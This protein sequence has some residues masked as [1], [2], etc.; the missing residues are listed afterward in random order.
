MMDVLIPS[1]YF[2]IP[3]L[4]NREKKFDPEKAMH[5]MNKHNVKNAFMPPTALK[6]IKSSNTKLKANLRSIGSG[7]ESLGENLLSWGR[8]TFG[9]TIHE[10]YGQTEANLL[11][12]NCSDVTPVKVGSMGKAIPGRKIEIINE[13]GEILPNGQ[14]GVIGSIATDPVT[15]KCYWNKP[16]QTTEKFSQDGKWL[17]TGDLGKKDNDGYFTFI[18]RD[19]DIIK[20]AGYRVGPC[21]IED[22]ISK[23]HSV[24][25]VAVVGSPDE[26]RNEVVKAF[27]VLK[28]EYQNDISN[29]ETLKS[30]IQNFVKTKLAAYEYPR[31]IEFIKELPMTTTGK[32]IRKELREREFK[33]K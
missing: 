24:K 4:A 7:G 21:E 12:G 8:E 22:C 28:D 25:V 2:G 20:T 16:K 11:I 13:K 31:K 5:L 10:F 29:H 1:A 14:I 17:L 30:E 3:V 26:L 33:K 19:D 18:G 23:H 27:I 6:L 9:I 32:I 15:F